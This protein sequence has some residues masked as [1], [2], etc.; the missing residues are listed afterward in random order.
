MAVPQ[1][2]QC[3]SQVN[4]TG[5]TCQRCG[6]PRQKRSAIRIA[7]LVFAW[8]LALGIV[9]ALSI[10]RAK[11]TAGVATRPEAPPPSSTEVAQETQAAAE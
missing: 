9:V 2:R 6:A 10:D 4:S 8:M 7:A 5:K 3:G 1:C 11:T